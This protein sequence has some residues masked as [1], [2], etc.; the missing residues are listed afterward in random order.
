MSYGFEARNGDNEIVIDDSFPVY[1]LSSSTT[2]TGTLVNN[3][4]SFPLPSSGV[5]RFWELNVGDS[6]SLAT[7]GFI[8]SKYTYNIRDVVLASSTPT[9]SGYGMAIYDGAGQKVYA[10]NGELLTIGDKYSVELLSNASK[11]RINVSDSW[12]AIETFVL[13]I[14]PNN[15]SFGATL[16]SGVRKATSTKMEFYGIGFTTAPPNNTILNPVGFITAK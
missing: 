4:I 1:E 12:V 6:I 15:A 10:S 11:P 14:I 13:N 16:S 9:P 5:L 3:R 8:G 7:G 2:I